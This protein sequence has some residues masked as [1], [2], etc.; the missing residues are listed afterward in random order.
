MRFAKDTARTAV[1]VVDDEPLLLDVLVRAA[2]LSGY[3][4][5]SAPTAEEAVE[6]LDRR[7]TP[8]VVTDLRMPGRGG[9]W[10]AW[11]LCS[12]NSRLPLRTPRSC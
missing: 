12:A 10:L 3:E 9:I 4:C 6:L 5:Q 11:T 2:R 1:T 8:I 7:P